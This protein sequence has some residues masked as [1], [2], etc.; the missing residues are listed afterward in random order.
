ML[1]L[2]A[3]KLELSSFV[4]LGEAFAPTN[5]VLPSPLLPVLGDNRNFPLSTNPKFVVTAWL[6]TTKALE[7]LQLLLL[8]TAW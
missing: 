4:P 6:D 1:L 3:V 2:V 8:L 7:E 5:L